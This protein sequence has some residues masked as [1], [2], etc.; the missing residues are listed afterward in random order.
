MRIIRD[1]SQEIEKKLICKNCGVE[2]GYL[3]LDVHERTNHDY[4]GGVY[5]VKYIT[6][7]NCGKKNDL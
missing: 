1:A 5:T 4:G 3:P 2:L 6:C 7:L